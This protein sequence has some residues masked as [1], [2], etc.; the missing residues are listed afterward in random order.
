[1]TRGDQGGKWLRSFAFSVAYWALNIFYGLLALGAAAL[2]GRRPTTWVI[3]RYVRR[4]VW[5][6]RT[7]AG[8]RLEVRGAERRPEGSFIIAAKHQSWGDGFCMYSQ[9]EDLAFVIGA[10][11][12]KYPGVTL[13]LRKLGV[14]TVD[15][16]GGRSSQRALM[17]EASVARAEGRRIL[18]YPEGHLAP[19][20]TRYPYRSGAYH[21]YRTFGVPVV[22]AATNLGLFW[23]G[24]EFRKRPGTAVLEFLEP[25]PPG[26]SRGEFMARLEA[27]VEARTA[28]LVAEATGRPV[29]AAE[30][31]PPP[32]EGVEAA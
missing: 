26:L 14:I 3:G 6:M 24:T 32:V 29:V 1:M 16:A 30:L 7:L 19:V 31:K 17:E 13:I 15:N 12:G 28:E 18:I 27:A 8:I 23:P 20:G 9:F 25:L 5:C 21:M 10:H 4:M 2:P 22:P 11:M